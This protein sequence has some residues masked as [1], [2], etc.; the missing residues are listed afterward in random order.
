MLSGS[1]THGGVTDPSRRDAVFHAKPGKN[2]PSGVH[3]AKSPMSTEGNK[4][5]HKAGKV[6]RKH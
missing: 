1:D 2:Y 5:L 6:R 3:G 4:S